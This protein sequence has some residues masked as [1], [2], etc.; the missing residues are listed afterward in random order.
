MAKIEKK[1]DQI[2]EISKKLVEL[3]DNINEI[4]EELRY[5]QEDFIPPE[6]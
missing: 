5:D 4:L 6:T 1:N 2:E 3:I